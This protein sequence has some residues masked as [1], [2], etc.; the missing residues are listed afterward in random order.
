MTDE[1]LWTLKI[2]N[3]RYGLRYGSLT[4]AAKKKLP[5]RWRETD[6]LS[7]SSFTYARP[8]YTSGKPN[9]FT[10]SIEV[11]GIRLQWTLQY[12]SAFFHPNLNTA[13]LRVN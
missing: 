10:S 9:A 4:D 12:V 5:S 11:F 7:G 8:L 1:E 13:I 2:S 3:L 6:D